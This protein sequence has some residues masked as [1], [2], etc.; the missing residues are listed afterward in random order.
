MKCCGGSGCAKGVLSLPFAL[1][2]LLATDP[3]VL[4]Q[5]LGIACR[6]IASHLIN[7][8]SLG[9]MDRVARM[10]GDDRAG[11][12]DLHGRRRAAPR[13]ASSVSAREYFAMR[14]RDLAPQMIKR[15]MDRPPKNRGGSS[16]P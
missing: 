5:V 6:G 7:L 13:P 10:A 9:H 11:G 8:D 12:R 3:K 15:D 1:R 2:F 4:S 14:A 16:P